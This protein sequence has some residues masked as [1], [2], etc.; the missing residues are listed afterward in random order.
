MNGFNDKVPFARAMQL[1]RISRAL[2]G[3]NEKDKLERLDK[4]LLKGF[5]VSDR[6]RLV[7]S[8]EDEAVKF[9]YKLDHNR[10]KGILKRTA[11]AK[12]DKFGVKDDK[13][14]G[15]AKDNQVGNEKNKNTVNTDKDFD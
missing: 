1:G 12:V 15:K 9:N 10:I 3:Y 14:T 2:Q 13:V 7:N 8:S 6:W 4:R 11:A 5:Y